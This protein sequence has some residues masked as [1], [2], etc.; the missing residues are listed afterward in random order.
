VKFTPD[1]EVLATAD[2]G[3]GMYFWQAANGREVEQLRGHEGGINSLAYT[4]DSMIMASAG[5][6]GTVQ[7]WD[8]WKYTRISS[9]KAHNQAALYVDISADGLILTAGADQQTKVWGQDGK[10]Q[11]AFKGTGDW[12]YAAC[13]G[14]NNRVVGGTWAGN[15]ILW[16]MAS[17]EEVAQVSTN[18]SPEQVAAN[19]AA[20]AQIAKNAGG[21]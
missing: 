10:E 4:A 20:A 16:D 9:F 17:G 11:K 7:L 8:T 19:Q 2:R 12:V 5:D 15:V 1:G 6:D 21:S 18:P 3:G 13:F 14:I